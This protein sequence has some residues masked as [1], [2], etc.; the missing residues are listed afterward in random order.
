VGS[1]TRTGSIPVCGMII[2]WE[3]RW[4]YSVSLIFL[5]IGFGYTSLDFLLLLPTGS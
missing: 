3:K 2:K 1:D 5:L 4:F